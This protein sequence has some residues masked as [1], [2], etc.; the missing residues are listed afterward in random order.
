MRTGCTIE[1]Q[2]PSEEGFG[3]IRISSRLFDIGFDK[4][5]EFIEVA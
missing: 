2:N 1:V 5:Q 4:P 3:K